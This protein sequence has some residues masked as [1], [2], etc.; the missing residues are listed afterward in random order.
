MSVIRVGSTG[1]YAA[2]WDA[3]FSGSKGKSSVRKKAAAKKAS[4]AVKKKVSTKASKVRRTR[5]G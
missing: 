3:I 4:K 2:G 5:K 1:K